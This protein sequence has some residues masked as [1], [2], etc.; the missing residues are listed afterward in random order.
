M[1]KVVVIGEQLTTLEAAPSFT[2][3]FA[4]NPTGQPACLEKLS[5]RI[6][7]SST[8][9]AQGAHSR[10]NVLPSSASSSL[11][12]ELASPPEESMSPGEVT[13]APGD[14][15]PLDALAPDAPVPAS[16]PVHYSKEDLQS[17]M[18]VCID[19][20]FQVQVLC[21]TE[22][23]GHREGQLKTR[24]PDLYYGKSHIE[25]YHFCQQCE[26]HFDT[27]DATTSNR[28]PFVAS[29]LCNRISFQWHQHKLQNQ[30]A[31]DPLS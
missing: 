8:E 19:S 1:P 26:D 2:I 30:A 23:A 28:T 20:I 11:P 16:A 15:G 25:C 9:M 12:K 3:L 5:K 22:P 31:E 29:F 17:M 18:K 21:P 10:R 4:P 7:P 14:V 6:V 13:P 24:L 27:A